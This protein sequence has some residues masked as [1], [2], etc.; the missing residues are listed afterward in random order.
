MSRETKSAILYVK[1]A[2]REPSEKTQGAAKL[3]ASKEAE[4]ARDLDAHGASPA[5]EGARNS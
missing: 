4:C 5:G 1:M 2:K 3:E